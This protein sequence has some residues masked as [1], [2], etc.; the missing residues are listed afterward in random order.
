M[1][2][3]QALK[4]RLSEI[5]QTGRIEWARGFAF[6][7]VGFL[8]TMFAMEMMG[9]CGTHPSCAVSTTSTRKL[10]AT[11]RMNVGEIVPHRERNQNIKAH[12]H[13]QG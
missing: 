8:A 10:Q 3:F 2:R 4:L 13:P 1:S 7:F 12:L 9:G 5:V 11:S 6:L